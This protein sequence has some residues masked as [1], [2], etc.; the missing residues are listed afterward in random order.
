M[1]WDQEHPDPP[2]LKWFAAGGRPEAGLGVSGLYRAGDGPSLGSCAEIKRGER[3]P[4]L[5]WWETLRQGPAS[6]AD[7]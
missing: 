6:Q 4:H 5:R 2:D 3:V 1:A 7:G